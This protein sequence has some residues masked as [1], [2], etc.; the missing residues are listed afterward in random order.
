MSGMLQI[1]DLLNPVTPEPSDVSSDEAAY[2]HQSS[3]HITS[4]SILGKHVVRS[5]EW[6]SK[7]TKQRGPVNFMPFEQGLSEEV[8]QEIAQYEVQSFGHIRESCEHIPYNSSKKDFFGKTG[9]ESIDVLKYEFRP[10]P[11]KELFTVMWDYDVGL[12][13]PSQMLDKNPGLREITPSITGGAVSAQGALIPLFGPGFLSECRRPGAPGYRDMTID[14]HVIEEATSDAHAAR[15]IRMQPNMALA[16]RPAFEHRQHPDLE[17]R[18]RQAT[19]G[20]RHVMPEH[21]RVIQLSP[22]RAPSSW[23]AINT[24]SSPLTPPRSS[25]SQRAV[26]SGNVDSFRKHEYV[27]DTQRGMVLLR[28]ETPELVCVYE[29]EDTNRDYHRTNSARAPLL[30]VVESYG[31]LKRRLLP[32]DGARVNGGDT[33]DRQHHARLPS[34]DVTNVRRRTHR[35]APRRMEDYHAATALVGLQGEQHNRSRG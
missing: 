29:K 23:R 22:Q 28:D 2:I 1:R 30:P 20:N 24:A 11:G 5:R 16:S 18:P 15:S 7:Y 9:R 25:N 35:D 4:G 10:Q 31:T 12:T 3:T 13:K 19:Y 32:P 27:E 34:R 26:M 8:L 14:P 17:A 21:G 33:S 6:A